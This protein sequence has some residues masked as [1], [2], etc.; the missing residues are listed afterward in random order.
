MAETE[1]EYWRTAQ[2]GITSDQYPDVPVGQ[3]EFP[4]EVY[5][6][7]AVCHKDCGRSEFIVDG[8]TQVCQHCGKMMF[9]IESNRYRLVEEQSG[10]AGDLEEEG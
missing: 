3:T 6:A 7:F 5:V 1:A 10:A 4:R 9:R 8:S 2:A